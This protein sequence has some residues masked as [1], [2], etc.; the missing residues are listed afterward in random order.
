MAIKYICKHCKSELGAITSA[1]VTEQEL[2]LDA[3]SQA[4]RYDMIGYDSQGNMVVQLV[5]N[6]CSEALARNPELM[7]YEN[8]L[9]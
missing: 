8:P 5:C 9:Q 6:Y 1:A 2:G 4:E 7:L 3:L